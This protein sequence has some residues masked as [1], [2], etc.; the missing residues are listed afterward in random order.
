MNIVLFGSTGQVGS[1]AHEQLKT[2][3]NVLTP[4]S[5]E[6]SFF[7]PESVEVYLKLHKPCLI[8]NAAAYTKVDDAE[9]FPEKA[10]AV[11]A[12]SVEKIARYCSSNNK[13]CIH[14]S[15]DYVFDGEKKSPYKE[16]DD[17]NPKSVY[18]KSK[19]QG[20]KF[21]LEHNCAAIIFRIGWVYSHGG[22]N[23]ML[24][25]KRL[26]R[27]R[28]EVLVVADQVGCP[29]F[30]PHVASAAVAVLK[31]AIRSGNE[32]SFFEKHR[33][34]YNLSNEVEKSWH[35]FAVEIFCAEKEKFPNEVICEQIV[36][37]PSTEFKTRA[38]RPAYSV[39]CAHKALKNFGLRL[40]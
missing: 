19:L 4:S 17:T 29:T 38:E 37:I 40:C 28:K 18:G 31:Q 23:F 5:C 9:E 1:C 24:T 25:M 15:T 34:V 26:L 21:L 32:F 35:Q 30:A 16:T 13:I 6:V 3:G 11:N 7:E 33:G 2:L 10:F 27:E 12:F 14:F 39:L 36:P 20:D 8:F 22:K